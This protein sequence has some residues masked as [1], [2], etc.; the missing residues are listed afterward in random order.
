MARVKADTSRK[1]AA[2]LAGGLVLGIGAATTLAAW[3]DSQHATATFTAGI[4]ALESKTEG[5]DWQSHPAADPA[6]L[7]AGTAGLTPGASGF[8]HL[9][10]RTTAESSVG[11]TV[12][13]GPVATDAKS[14]EAMIAVLESRFKVIPR[15]STCNASALAEATFQSVA[16]K[17]LVADQTVPAG[18]TTAVRYCL[19]VR[20]SPDAPSAV[21]GTTASLV[22]TFTGT[23]T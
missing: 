16:E 17:P 18:G 8:G 13:L 20:M 9:D 12:V 2:V 3:T 19:E 6:K 22:W 23:N 14:D 7:V 15:G 1:I 21:Q 11:G 5:T 10:V 4:F